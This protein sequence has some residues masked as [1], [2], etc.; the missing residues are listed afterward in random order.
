MEMVEMNPPRSSSTD[1]PFDWSM[2]TDIIGALELQIAVFDELRA[3][4][5]DVTLGSTL[6]LD[7][8]VHYLGR[9][10]FVFGIEK[11]KL[12][13]R[14]SLK[15]PIRCVSSLTVHVKRLLFIRALLGMSL[16]PVSL[17][18]PC[19]TSNSLCLTANHRLP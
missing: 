16:S 8:I 14:V 10:C 18:T 6:A 13:P 19:P 15:L 12:F 4:T 2:F 3:R 1:L 9:F 11:F 5:V 17:R 7:Y